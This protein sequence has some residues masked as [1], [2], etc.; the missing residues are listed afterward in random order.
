MKKQIFFFLFLVLLVP[1]LFAESF[2]VKAAV[3]PFVGENGVAGAVTVVADKD[4]VLQLDV[5]GYANLEDN[6]PM[7]GDTPIWIASQSKPITAV[8][9]MMLVEEGKLDLDKPITD[10]L[11]ELAEL[12]VGVKQED[13]NTLL[14]PLTSPITLRLLLSHKSGMVWVPSLQQKHRIDVLPFSKAITTCVMT[15]LKSQPGTEH[16]Y[17][18]MGINIAATAVEQVTEMPFEDFLQK[19]L[20]APLGM[21]AT[22]FWPTSEQMKKLAIIYRRDK[23]S[24]RLVPVPNSQLTYPLE[25]RKIRYPEAAGGLFSTPNDL[26]KFYQMLLGKGE[27]HGVRLL[28]PES[29]AAI[30]EKQLGFPHDYGL[31]FRTKGGVFGH[32]GAAGTDSLVDTNLDLTYLWF[33]QEQGIPEAGKAKEAFFT[34]V[35]ET[36]KKR[37]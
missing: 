7:S 4:K 24:G 8:A 32:A 13:G 2:P 21:Q 15:P 17:S 31:G 20:F 22:T 10:Y 28:K 36:A 25:D 1:A 29:V 19:R 33:V 27:Y 37:Q 9:V 35:R 34:V 18:N 14:V 5:F 3:E 12:R 30:A 16:S 23:E 11:P 26:V 6:V